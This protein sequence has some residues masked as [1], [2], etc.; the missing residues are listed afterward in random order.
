[1]FRALL[2]LVVLHGIVGFPTQGRG[3]LDMSEVAPGIYR[4]KAPRSSE[5]FDQLQNMGIRT[6]LDLRLVLKG[7]MAEESQELWS[8]G[9]RYLQVSIGYRPGKDDCAE[10]AYE[11]L[12]DENNRP[13]FVHCFLDADRT[14][15]VIAL[16]RVRQQGW[17][18]DSAYAEMLEFGLKKRLILL[19]RYFWQYAQQ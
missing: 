5:D 13:I 16:Y 14:S 17:S 19:H 9:I 8:R 15:L 1:M 6:V 11:S 3:A 10:R 2:F 18:L 12:L 4:G 7:Q